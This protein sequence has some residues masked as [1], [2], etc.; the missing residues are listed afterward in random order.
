MMQLIDLIEKTAILVTLTGK[1]DV[2]FNIVSLSLWQ[3]VKHN[4]SSNL[5]M[6]YS[7]FYFR[8]LGKGGEGGGGG[9]GSAGC[10]PLLLGL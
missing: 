10:I 3:A 8:A 9:R 7:C 6:I 5:I 1:G 2:L 4:L